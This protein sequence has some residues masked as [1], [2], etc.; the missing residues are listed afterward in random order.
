MHFSV[1]RQPE[2]RL[3]CRLSERIKAVKTQRF[4]PDDTV[5]AVRSRREPAEAKALFALDV[6]QN[7]CEVLTHLANCHTVRQRKDRA[8]IKI[9]NV[10]F[11]SRRFK[12]STEI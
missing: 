8:K 2:K 4:V 1:E 11:K 5:A 7:K 6:R 12:H 3:T 9:Y 10:W